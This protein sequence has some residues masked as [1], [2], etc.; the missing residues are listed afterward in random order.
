MTESE[1]FPHD[2]TVFLAKSYEDIMEYAVERG[3]SDKMRIITLQV[4]NMD[5][6]I[7]PSLTEVNLTMNQQGTEMIPNGLRQALG[8]EGEIMHTLPLP[9]GVQVFKVG[10]NGE[11]QCIERME[12][13]AA[14]TP[15]ECVDTVIDQYHEPLVKKEKS[16]VQCGIQIEN[17]TDVTIHHC[18]GRQLEGLQPDVSVEK[19]I[20]PARLNKIK[21][22]DV[23]KTFQCKLCSYTFTQRS[24]LDRHMRSHSDER[25]HK[26][27]LCEKAFRTITLL[28]NHINTHTGTRP[29]KCPDCA[30]AFVTS[31][32]VVRHRRYKH[33]HEKPFKCSI[34]DYASV[35]VSK[36]KR[37][38]RSHTGE[39]PFPCTFCSYASRDTY[40]LKRH[41]RTHSGVHL[42]KQHSYTS[43]SMKCRYCE[44]TFH[45]RY[46]LIQHQKTH[47]NEKRFKC[48]QCDY[49]CKQKRHMIMHKRIHTGEKPFSCSQCDKQ[50]RQKQLLDLHF[51]KHHDPSFIPEAYI[52]SQCCKSFT[53]KNVM[54]R[55]AER[56][57]NVTI[58]D[59]SAM[60]M[61]KKRRIKKNKLE[62]KHNAE[63]KG[64]EPPVGLETQQSIEVTDDC[65][66]KNDVTSPTK[67]NVIKRKKMVKG[68]SAGV[69][70]EPQEFAGSV[71]NHTVEI[72]PV[73][74]NKEL[75]T[76]N[77]QC[78]KT[79]TPEMILKRMV[80]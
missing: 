52:C 24:N 68:K 37:H 31:G 65:H 1:I 9:E 41:M 7:Q 34:C 55:H 78:K 76:V 15:E 47:R 3:V 5:E 26:C 69:K 16:S 14:H 25:P 20:S 60:F 66:I 38:I 35:E 50:F 12:L 58:Q 39:R 17:N 45:E 8:G 23:K 11:M 53:R 61:P 36:L 22:K 77:G 54:K 79:I 6:H 29:H 56:C 49:A 62:Y 80:L 73:D 57:G 21:K 18:R 40:K 74:S 43:S 71:S 2:T 33:T 19:T 75:T 30:M 67:T 59:G 51:K 10:P 46:A 48:D 28:Q 4:V 13:D 72:I 63:A 44:A 42:R 70:L 64:D 27:H 32:E